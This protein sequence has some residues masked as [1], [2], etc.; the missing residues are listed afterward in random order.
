LN[1]T[2]HRPLEADLQKV[3]ICTTSHP[4][5]GLRHGESDEA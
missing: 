5:L 3:T 4:P 1:L 2:F